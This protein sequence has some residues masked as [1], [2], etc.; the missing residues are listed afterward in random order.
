MSGFA[1]VRKLAR[2]LRLQ[3]RMAPR[4]GDILVIPCP[5]CG[6]GGARLMHAADGSGVVTERLLVW[7]CCR[8]Q[9]WAVTVSSLSRCWRKVARG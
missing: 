5:R 2:R 3:V 8:W 6:R 1:G 7:C 4:T 9:W